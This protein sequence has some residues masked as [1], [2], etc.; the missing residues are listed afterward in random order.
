[1]NK[2][3]LIL[4]IVTLLLILISIYNYLTYLKLRKAENKH[5]NK[6]IF[7]YNCN[8]TYERIQTGEI[9][10][11]LTFSLSILLLIVLI[12]LKIKKN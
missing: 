1:M 5:D 2:E 3:Y 7:K 8:I 6:D 10:N 11:I 9:T 12:F 4:I